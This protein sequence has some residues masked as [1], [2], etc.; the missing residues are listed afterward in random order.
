M[1]IGYLFRN[2]NGEDHCWKQKQAYSPE[3]HTTFE[4]LTLFT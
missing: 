2:K 3:F 1:I 4:I